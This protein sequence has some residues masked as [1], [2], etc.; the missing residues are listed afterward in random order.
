M[1]SVVYKLEGYD[2]EGSEVTFG[3]IGSEHFQVDP[4]SGNV[5]LVKSL[6]REV[7]RENIK[8]SIKRTNSLRSRKRIHLHSL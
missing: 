1:G 3:S 8:D 5:T 7:M 6:D 2:P 4:T